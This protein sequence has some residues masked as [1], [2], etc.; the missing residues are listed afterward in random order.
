MG[1]IKKQLNP[2]PKILLLPGL[3]LI[4]IGNDKK[5]SDIV[6]DIGESWI[7]TVLSAESITKFNQFQNLILLIYIEFRTSKK[8]LN[9]N[10]V[11]YWSNSFSYRRSWSNW[12]TNCKRF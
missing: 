3:G 2:I 12:F 1:G 7:E 4:G 5:S 11:L 8:L 6:A 9:K 10:L